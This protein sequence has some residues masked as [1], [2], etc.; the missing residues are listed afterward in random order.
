MASEMTTAEMVEVLRDRWALLGEVL[1]A[2]GV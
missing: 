2:R 1:K